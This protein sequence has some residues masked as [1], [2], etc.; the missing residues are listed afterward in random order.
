VPRRLLLRALGV[1]GDEAGENV[2]VGEV[3][4]PAIRPPP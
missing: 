3:G 4:R 2:I 1:E